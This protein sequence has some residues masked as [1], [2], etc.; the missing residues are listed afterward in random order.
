MPLERHPWDGGIAGWAYPEQLEW[1]KEQARSAYRIVEIGAYKGRMTNALASSTPGRVWTVDHWMGS[2]PT[3]A[4]NPALLRSERDDVT[5]EIEKEGGREAVFDEFLQNVGRFRNL[6]VYKMSSAEA[7]GR[8]GHLTFDFVWIDASHDYQSVYSDIRRWGAYL[9]D[10]GL[11]AGHDA[12][13]PGVSR[14]VGEL[15][16][17]ANTWFAFE[18]GIWWQR[19]I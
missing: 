13:Y 15:L 17:R 8:L 1:L 5:D 12:E 19:G 16:P 2:N 3:W 9:T 4:D 7:W 11:I 10:G 18:S 6:T 14:A